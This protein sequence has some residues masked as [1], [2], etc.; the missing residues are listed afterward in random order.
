VI[1]TL[2]KYG[3]KDEKAMFTASLVSPK[4]MVLKN[5][6]KPGPKNW[7]GTDDS[8]AD[9]VAR[10]I[11]ATRVAMSIGFV[12]TGI[13]LLIGVTVGSL[14]GYFGGWVDMIGMRII[15]MFMTIPTIFLL[16][17]ILAFFPPEWNPY[18]IY[19]MMV[20]IGLTSWTGAARF[21]R[22]EFFRLREMDFIDAAKACGLPLHSILFKHMLP[23]GVAPV[24]VDASFGVAAAIFI[25][26]NLS[27]LGFGIK[28]PE[29]SWG[30]MLAAATD[31]STGVFYWWLAIYPGIMIFLTVFCYNLLGDAMRDAIDPHTKRQAQI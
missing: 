6:T 31:P 4:G 13:G 24:L 8:G 20:V 23:N 28:P 2:N 30:Q 21:I 19:A 16:L 15:E 12:A 3:Q 14:M 5:S 9:V 29:P 26:T 7:A 10:I 25:E 11:A 22:A 18:M 27:F 17:T 1:T